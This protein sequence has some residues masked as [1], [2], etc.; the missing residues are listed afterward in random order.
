M[1]HGANEN[2]V[3]R[4]SN[5]SSTSTP[6]VHI[7]QISTFSLTD[8]RRAVDYAY[9]VELQVQREYSM[10]YVCDGYK[11]VQYQPTSTTR[12]A[13][14]RLGIHTRTNRPAF[15]RRDRF[16]LYLDHTYF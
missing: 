8:V 6:T 16:R 5:S 14:K 13:A 11:T 15:R 3:D 9:T 10:Q 7:L 2:S 1:L 12:R 4:C